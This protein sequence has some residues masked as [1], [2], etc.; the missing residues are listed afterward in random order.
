V[1]RPVSN[2]YSQWRA[3]RGAPSVLREDAGRPRERLLQLIWHHQRLRRDELRTLDGLPLRVLH[4]GFWNHEAGPDFRDAVVQF[5]DGPP[6]SADVEVDLQSSGWHAHGHDQ[7]PAFK[8]VGLHV[9]WDGDKRLAVPTLALKAFL[10]AP[11]EEL[12]NWLS[13]DAA[14]TF[15]PAL[16]GQCSAPLRTLPAERVGE[17]L[18]EA[19]LVRLESKATRLQARARQ[20]GWEQALWEG[21]FRAL[22]YKHNVWPMQRLAELR[23]RL[24]PPRAKG[25]LLELQAKLLGV[26][27]LMPEELPRAQAGAN[28]YARR[29]WDVWWRERDAFADC[30]LPETLWRFHG[31]RPANQP[32]RRL[33][34]AAHWLAA[35]DLAPRLERWC[36]ATVKDGELAESLLGV[37]QTAPDDFW[38]RHWTLRSPRLSRTQPMLGLTR[39]TDLAVNVVLPWLCVRAA[40]GKNIGLRAEMER[41][42]LAWP[43]GQDNAVLRLARV[44]LLGGASARV[45]R[46]AAAQQGLLQIVRDFCEHSNALC[47]QCQFPELV[48]Q[49]KG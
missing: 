42:Y 37:L 49:W 46:G 48:K 13:S 23:P 38:G 44:R 7:N 19:G 39:A 20:A 31:L 17:L 41:R 36:A 14:T 27:G 30:V 47:A 6:R 2:F 8:R 26:A 35:G 3:H 18:R 22:G 16:A 40:E 5:A 33:A 25:A 34:L 12:A 10:D 9:V 28:S 1:P 24:V 45:W 15:P 21:L 32:Q 29:L 43:A 4:P 11:L